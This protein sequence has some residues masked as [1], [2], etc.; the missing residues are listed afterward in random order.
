MSDLFDRWLREQ[1]HERH[2]PTGRR[3]EIAH[4]ESTLTSLPYYGSVPLL[5]LPRDRSTLLPESYQSRAEAHYWQSSGRLRLNS[6]EWPVPDPVFTSLT[7]SSVAD[8]VNAKASRKSAC[9]PHRHHQHRRNAIPEESSH[10]FALQRYLAEPEELSEQFSREAVSNRVSKSTTAFSVPPLLNYE[11]ELP[12]K[13]L[14]SLKRTLKRTSSIRLRRR[15]SAATVASVASEETIPVFEPERAVLPEDDELERK[16]DANKLVQMLGNELNTSAASV[17]SSTKLARI[18]GTDLSLG[19]SES[20]N[21]KRNHTVTDLTIL[22]SSDLVDRA[23]GY[24]LQRSRSEDGS[25]A[26]MEQVSARVQAAAVGL[27]LRPLPLVK[28][29]QLP[30]ITIEI[31]PEQP[32]TEPELL[33]IEASLEAVAVV[34]EEEQWDF[35]SAGTSDFT[36]HAINE[37]DPLD[38]SE[39]NLSPA[40]LAEKRPSDASEAESLPELIPAISAEST[41]SS[42]DY[43]RLEKR[44]VDLPR[45]DSFDAQHFAIVCERLMGELQEQKDARAL[46]E[47]LSRQAALR[48]DSPMLI[49]STATSA[50]ASAAA[51]VDIASTP[52]SEASPISSA[53]PSLKDV[54]ILA[55]KAAAEVGSPTLLASTA[56]QQAAKAKLAAA[57]DALKRVRS[58]VAVPYSDTD[59]EALSIGNG[60]RRVSP[61][62]SSSVSCP[63]LSQAATGSI[64]PSTSPRMG[65]SSSSDRRSSSRR[66]RTYD[67]V[68]A[69]TPRRAE[70]SI[71]V[72]APRKVEALLA[73][74]IQQPKQNAPSNAASSANQQQPPR[75]PNLNGRAHSKT[76][77]ASFVPQMHGINEVLA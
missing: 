68:S 6:I 18:L 41:T 76:K 34:T 9:L 57:R 71:G 43:F 63:S 35:T 22:T 3:Q 66:S 59:I 67:G 65:M 7:T 24:D 1:Q 17:A 32:D 27:G 74:T 69:P 37:L 54:L 42:E 25:D 13:M 44:P 58:N 39:Q 70:I 23:F 21:L 55:K 45:T 14:K 2:Y 36:K 38:T 5:N 73:R 16:R 46:R 77:S 15:S 29:Q 56:E 48:I 52:V 60:A 75:R 12:P 19:S 51:S 53:E 30:S 10:S 72:A 8:I 31:E 20:L 26:A 50:T 11:P 33:E 4:S 64:S 47:S 40:R 49:S 28:M 62:L 61:Q